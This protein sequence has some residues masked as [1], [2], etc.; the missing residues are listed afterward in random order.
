MTSISF[1]VTGIYDENLNQV[2]TVE[3]V[4]GSG[5]GLIANVPAAAAAFET[6]KQVFADAYATDRGGVVTFDSFDMSVT[7]DT[8][9][10]VI[11]YGSGS[12]LTINKAAPSGNAGTNGNFYF[13]AHNALGTPIS[14]GA[15]NT[16]LR[17]RGQ[18]SNDGGQG[19][20][21]SIP[22]D[23]V[24]FTVLS[25]TG[26]RNIVATVTYTDNTTD[27]ITDHIA[28]GAGVDDTFFA[29]QAPLGKGITK[30]EITAGTDGNSFFAIDDLAFVIPEPSVTGFALLSAFGL[31]ARRKRA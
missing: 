20:A 11:S 24:A 31:L 21:F 14:A 15:Y 8:P 5:M 19:Y 29:F 25:R 1:N 12:I 13:E 17:S 30:L 23:A 22:L 27:Q 9:Q 26:E 6:W 3:A 18:G 7:T 16:F 28:S 2:N 4:A 10:L